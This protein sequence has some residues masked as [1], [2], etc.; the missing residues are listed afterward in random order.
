M[1]RC[2]EHIKAHR[3][4]A[5]AADSPRYR[6]WNTP[7]HA[8]WDPSS[9]SRPASCARA[10]D[11]RGRLVAWTV[12]LA[13]PPALHAASLASNVRRP[14]GE[15]LLL[16]PRRPRPLPPEPPAAARDAR[17]RRLLRCGSF[18]RSGVSCSIQRT[19]WAMAG[20]GRGRAPNRT[21][22]CR[23]GN[24]SLRALRPDAQPRGAERDRDWD[25]VWRL[26][27]CKGSLQ[28]E[29]TV[30]TGTNGLATTRWAARMPE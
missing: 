8:F 21:G 9:S 10:T 23:R 18:Q 1:G 5:C 14:Y 4:D 16:C 26:P 15:A 22:L 13:G 25:P 7:G 11:S 6:G 29:S 3:R 28:T 30:R 24:R 19:R 27:F 17:R 2:H 20:R 12:T